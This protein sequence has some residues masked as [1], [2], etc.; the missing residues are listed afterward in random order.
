[1]YYDH[2]YLSRRPR[3]HHKL[4]DNNSI[5]NQNQ[6]KFISE[7]AREVNKIKFIKDIWMKKYP[8]CYGSYQ[9]IYSTN[10]HDFFYNDL[11]GIP[12]LTPDKGFTLV[13]PHIEIIPGKILLNADPLSSLQRNM[14]KY[15]IAGALLIARDITSNDMGKFQLFSPMWD[16]ILI[17]PDA[18]V[19]LELNIAKD[20]IQFKI[21]YKLSQVYIFIAA[22]NEN[23]DPLTYSET[24]SPF[25]PIP[26]AIINEMS[27][28]NETL[29]K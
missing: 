22:L 24:I 9:K 10:Y 15:I 1:M 11:T 6:F 8:E 3:Q 17:I 18:P 23:G 2:I 26:S 20:L 14:G 5:Y 27:F 28:S 29:I 4:V 7:I 21:D 16:K 19:H 25:I 12:K 13:N